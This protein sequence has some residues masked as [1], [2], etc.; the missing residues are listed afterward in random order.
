MPVGDREAV[1]LEQ[2][3]EPDQRLRRQEGGRRR[4][5]HLSRRD[6]PRARALDLGVEIAVDDVVPGA[7]GAAHGEGADEEQHHVPDID[8]LS[9]RDGRKPDATTSTEAAA[10]RSRSDD[11]GG[12]A[13][14]TAAAMRARGRRPS[15]RS[16]RR[17]VPRAP[18]IAPAGYRSTCRRCPR[19]AWCW[20]HRAPAAWCPSASLRLGPAGCAPLGRRVADVLGLP[21][22]PSHAGP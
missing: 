14:D 18:F 10:A 11:R 7:A 15:F 19:R 4:D 3:R 12:R 16:N 9:G 13:A 1:E 2:H 6:R 20:M 5:A 17:R 8:M 22:R 21:P